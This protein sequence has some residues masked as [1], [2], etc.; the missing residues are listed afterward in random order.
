[1]GFSLL[2]RTN[3]LQFKIKVA[4]TTCEP[5][6]ADE[7]RQLKKW[8]CKNRFNWLSINQDDL[9]DSFFYIILTNPRPSNIEGLTY[10]WDFD[11]TADC[12]H[13]WSGMKSKKATVNGSLNINLYLS[14]DYDEYIVRP[15]IT[16]ISTTTGTINI[17]NNS[18]GKSM[19]IR[20]CTAGEVLKIDC[21]NH[22]QLSSTGRV[23]LD[24]WNKNYIEFVENMN[25]I[26]LSGNFTV[27]FEYRLP[28]RIGG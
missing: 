10:A 24:S 19:I 12:G 14:I 1:M 6:N 18:I 26:T 7:Q 9:Y 20:N 27:D 13:A 28:V 3:P 22:K 16:L 25:N 2:E 23:L 5:F 17:T 8:L 21:L 4:K 11:C 15:F